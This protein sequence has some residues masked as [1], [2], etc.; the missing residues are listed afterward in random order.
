MSMNVY[1]MCFSPTG[2]PRKVLNILANELGTFQE[3]DFSLP[4]KNYGMYRFERGDVCLVGVPSFGG[5]VPERALKNLTRV[6]ADHGAAILVVTYGNRAYDDTL[7]ELR[8]AMEGCGFR[9]VAVI[10]AATEHSIMHRYG[11]GRPDARDKKELKAMI[12]PIQKK[13]LKP[14]QWKDFFVPGKYPY[15]EYSGVP[16]KPKANKKCRNCGICAAKC[17][18]RAIPRKHPNKTNKNR[19]ISCMRCIHMC[20]ERAR[21][22]DWKMSLLASIMLRKACSGRKTNQLFL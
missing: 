10:A 8:K 15:R 7:L 13:L 16:L 17:P 22:L 1:T 20:P 9:V 4:R 12:K 19:C 11:T 21:Q 18:A 3:I 2:G 14:E 6:K 5:R